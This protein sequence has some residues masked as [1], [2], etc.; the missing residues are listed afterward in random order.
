[1]RENLTGC[2]VKNILVKTILV[3]SNVGWVGLINVSKNKSAVAPENALTT[4]N[5]GFYSMGIF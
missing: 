3:A 4:F 1:M 5:K 2:F